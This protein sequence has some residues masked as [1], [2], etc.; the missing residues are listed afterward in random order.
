MIRVFELR[1]RA[2]EVS[3]LRKRQSP[4]VVACWQIGRECHR[5]GMPFLG[6]FPV[7]ATIEDVTAE[8]IAIDERAAVFKTAS[9]LSG[10]PAASSVSVTQQL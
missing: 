8:S 6:I 1:G 10:W 7:A 5:L 9:A 4:R 2:V 3:V